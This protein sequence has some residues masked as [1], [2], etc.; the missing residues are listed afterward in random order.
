MFIEGLLHRTPR[1]NECRQA[2]EAAIGF[3]EEIAIHRA[4][5]QEPAWSLPEP[6]ECLLTHVMWEAA[7]S[8]GDLDLTP[9]A[10]VAGTIADATA[11]FLA[12]RGMSRVVTNNG[13]DCAIRLSPGES[14]SVGIRPD[15]A[16]GL[17][18]HRVVLTSGM[19]IGGVCTSGLGGRSFTRGIASSA[20]VFAARAAVADAAA[21]AVANATYV[22]SRQVRRILADSIDPFTDLKGVE[23]TRSVGD[24]SANEI[25]EALSRGIARAEDLVFRQVI[26]GACIVVKGRMECTGKL[27]DLLESLET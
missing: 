19:S 22:Q 25:E 26:K 5:V 6:P 3:L 18:T 9:M 12:G 14:L 17:V 15:V 2:A 23:I 1:P 8:V 10:V 21:T 4:S 16:R 20:T 24:L 13:G 27:S 11:D 7:R